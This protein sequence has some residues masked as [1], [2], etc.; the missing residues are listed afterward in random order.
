M[1]ETYLEH[2]RVERRLADHTLDSYS[3]DLRGL[4]AF[5]AAQERAVEGLDR[6]ALEAFV[7]QQRTAGLSPR[8]VAR[9]QPRAGH[10]VS[11]HHVAGE[12]HARALAFFDETLF[13]VV[14]R[15]YREADA[16]V[17]SAQMKIAR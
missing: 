4:V 2:L 10:N 13:S 16:A 7:R 11:L 9:W 5:A 14:S 12:Y 15:V 17:G 6:R 1:I 3:R 8:S